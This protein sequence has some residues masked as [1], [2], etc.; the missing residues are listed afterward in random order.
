[1]HHMCHAFRAIS[2][3]TFY[4]DKYRLLYFP[5]YS[6]SEQLITISCGET[7]FLTVLLSK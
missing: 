7:H 4:C 1:M 6:L 5:H 3:F 2:Y